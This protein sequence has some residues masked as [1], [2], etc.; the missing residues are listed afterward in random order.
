MNCQESWQ[1]G[2]TWRSGL[3]SHLLS[4]LLSLL[5]IILSVLTCATCKRLPCEDPVR[6]AIFPKFGEPLRPRPCLDCHEREEK[7]EQEQQEAQEEQEQQEAKEDQ[8]DPPSDLF[9]S[10]LGIMAEKEKAANMNNPSGR[11]I[12]SQCLCVGWFP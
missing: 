5:S 6:G 9:G 8:E 10:M 7:E 4:F 3:T 2:G 12:Q 11:N 1:E